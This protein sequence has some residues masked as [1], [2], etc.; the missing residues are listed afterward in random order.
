MALDFIL[1][2]VPWDTIFEDIVDEI[3][4]GQFYLQSAEMAPRSV[5]PTEFI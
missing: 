5:L 3:P 4:A 1:S 2:P